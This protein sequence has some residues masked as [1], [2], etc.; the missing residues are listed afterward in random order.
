MMFARY[1]EVIEAGEMVEGDETSPA[2]LA[3]M[4]LTAL[5]NAS[6]MPIDK[7]SRWLGF[8]QGILVVRGQISVSDERDFSR[9]LFHSAYEAEGIETPST[10]QRPAG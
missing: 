5:H 9:P 10:L 3:W 6:E 1:L 2:H 4:C 8:I 7:L